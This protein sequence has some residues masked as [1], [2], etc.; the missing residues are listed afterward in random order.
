MKFDETFM[1]LATKVI[2]AANREFM[3]QREK[4]EFEP[5]SYSGEQVTDGGNKFRVVVE[6]TPRERSAAQLRVSKN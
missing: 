2:V 4:Y 5:F 1:L 6:F 3:A